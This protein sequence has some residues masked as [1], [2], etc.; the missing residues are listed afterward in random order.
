MRTIGKYLRDARKANKI[1]LDSLSELTK[2]KKEFLVALEAQEWSKLPEFPVVS[3]FVKN[4]ADAVDLD[5]NMANAILKR[6]YPPA[7]QFINPKPE[8]KKG[9]GWSPKLTFLTGVGIIIILVL[10]YLGF[11]YYQFKQPPQ[12]SVDLP[13]ENEIIFEK[14]VEVA[15]KTDPDAV[16]RVNDLPVIVDQDGT[17]NVKIEIAENTGIIIVRAI[18]RNGQEVKVE[19]SIKYEVK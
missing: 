5:K 10:G 2:I 14:E 9:F 6:D 18:S 16:I 15:G 11:T 3:G 17:F 13:H 19:R 12:L 1:S 4:V 7:K 8:I